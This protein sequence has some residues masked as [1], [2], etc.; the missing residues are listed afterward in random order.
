MPAGRASRGAVD[1]HTGFTEM[2]QGLLTILTQCAVEV[3]G[4]PAAVFRPQVNSRFEVGSGQTTGSRGSLF[5]G[6]SVIDAAEKLKADLNAGRTLEISSAKSTP[7]RSR[8]T[9][10]PRRPIEERQDQDPHHLRL[11]HPG[12]GARR[13]RRRREGDRRP[14]RR[15]RAKSAA[16]RGADP[17]RGGYGARLR[18]DRGIAVQGRNSRDLQAARDRRFTRATYA[19]G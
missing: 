12:R 11:R 19:G 6:R 13:K 9:T 3:T 5:A 8:S 16:M 10:P 7:A 1:L 17:G 18:A 14:R 2:G 15:A 4:L